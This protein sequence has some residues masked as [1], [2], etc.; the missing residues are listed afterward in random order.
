[1]SYSPTYT[2]EELIL[3]IPTLDREQVRSVSKTIREEKRLYFTLDYN[4]LL[5]LI[6]KRVIELSFEDYKR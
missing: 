1:M 5:V 2:F 3:R 6:S 4:Y